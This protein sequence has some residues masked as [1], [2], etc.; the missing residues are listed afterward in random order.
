MSELQPLGG[1]WWYVACLFPPAC[2][3]QFAFA[4]IRWECVQRGLTLE[5]W[6]IPITPIYEF[7]TL[8]IILTLLLDIIIFSALTW[9]FDKVRFS[10]F[11]PSSFQMHACS[12]GVFFQQLHCYVIGQAGARP[13]VRVADCSVN[14]LQDLTHASLQH[15]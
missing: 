12:K 5:T 14:L 9:Y 15:L 3:N 11:P 4:I 2:L 13:A 10:S 1:R 7:S 8:S 6:R